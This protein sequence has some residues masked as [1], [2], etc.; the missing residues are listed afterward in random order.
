M[1][2]IRE[3]L[4]ESWLALAV[5]LG[6]A[7][8]FSLDLLLIMLATGALGGMVASLFTDS[9]AITAAVAIITSVGMLAVVRPGLARR[10]HHGPELRLGH[11]KLVGTQG[12]VTETVTSLAPGRVRL[13]GEIWSAQPYDET[14][15]IESGETVEVF[16]I[17]GATAYVH[18]LPRLEP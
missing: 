10:L 7:E 4:T 2:W 13:A 18:P 1:D 9:L 3:H 17:R 14:L 11:G 5:V 16:E 15:T 6:V 8:M 12:I